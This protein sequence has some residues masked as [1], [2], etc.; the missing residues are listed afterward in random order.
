MNKMLADL[1]EFVFEINKNYRDKTAYRYIENDR[2]VDKSFADLTR[3]CFAVATWLKNYGLKGD[4]VAIIGGTSYPWIVTFLASAIGGNVVIPI[5]KMLPEEEILHLLKEGEARV[6]FVSEEFEPWMKDIRETIGE[7]GDVYSFSGTTYREMLRTEREK[8]PK[9]KPE[10]PCLLLFTSGTTGTGKGVLISHKNIVA[11]INEIYRMDYGREVAG[12]PVVMSVLP[13]YHT[14]E[15]TVGNLGI[16]YTGTTICI[17]DKLENVVE[18]L[19]RFKPSVMV[20]VPAIAELIYK[21]IMEA[22]KTPKNKRKVKFAKRMDNTLGKIN[23]DA[24]RSLY[25]PIYEAFGGNLTTIVVGGSAL[26]P[27]IAKTLDEFGFHIYQ[28]YGMTECAPLIAANYPG[29]DRIGSVGKPVSY[30]NVKIVNE[31]IL[32]RGDGVMLSYYNNPEE[33]KNAFAGG[34]F[35][36]GDLGYIDNEG[37]L[38]ITGRAKNLIILDNGKNI[39]PEEIEGYLLKIPGVKDAFVYEDVGKISALIVPESMKEATIREIKS[40][41]RE[42]NDKVPAYKRVVGLSFRPSDLPKTTTLK[43]K[44]NEVLKWIKEKNEEKKAEYIAPTTAEQKR[45]VVAMEQVLHVTKIGIKDDFFERGGDSMS[46]LEFATIIGVQAQDIYEYPTV[47]LLEEMI[48]NSQS[49]ENTEETKVDVNELI[50]HNND[51]IV[52]TEPQCVLLTGATGFLGAHILR[53][54]LQKNLKVVCLVRNVDKLRPT[55]RAYFPKEYESFSYKTVKGDIELPRFGLSDT[56]YEVLC[57]RVD[58]VFHVAANVHHAGHYEDFE[59][60]NVLGTQHVIDFCVDAN[61][62]LQHTSTASVSGSGTVE[63]KNADAK[64]DEFTLDIGQKYTQNV[65]IHS[66]YKSEERVLLARENGLRANIFRIGNLTWRISD[67]KFQINA[68][69]NGFLERLKGI[70]KV[71]LY[72]NEIADYPIDFTPVDECAKAYVL[73]ALNHHVNNI[74]NLYN[75]NIYNIEQLSKKFML[76]AKRVPRELFEKS[77]REQ[78]HDKSVMVLSFYNAIASSSKNIPMSNEYTN[79]ELNKLGFK[80]SKIGLSYLRFVKGFIK[81]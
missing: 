2:I 25:K 44:R 76:H 79:A 47:E 49:V 24:R 23:I 73:L 57:N 36:T 22:T 13:I 26:R 21:K 42:L 64:F 78:I 20:V 10:D 45:L 67:G 41:I 34:W 60:S 77:L 6:V 16:L 56:E 30:M 8:I 19:K 9:V 18:N 12:D 66:K 62:V 63:I 31:E 33:N 50:R 68:D 70:L 55:L 37:Y 69:D 17:N 59:R 80:W 71:R 52:N 32:L 81:L 35:R 39:Y 5:D 75:P 53:E 51:L 4:K 61:A 58:M 14:F 11:N 72:S 1:Q 27:E 38:Y 54:L 48:L 7:Q 29:N 43:T 46:A 28:G 40:G 15:L 65:Y 3:D 74:Y